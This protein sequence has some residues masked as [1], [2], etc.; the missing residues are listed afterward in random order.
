MA[1]KSAEKIPV[2][3]EPE[4][5]HTACEVCETCG[6][7]SGYI[8][9]VQSALADLGAPNPEDL[10]AKNNRYV[11]GARKAGMS[12]GNAAGMII[13]LSGADPTSYT[14]RYQLEEGNAGAEWE[15][16]GP[17]RWIKSIGR[18][19]YEIERESEGVF[20]LL[21]WDA[22][23][24]RW[25]SAK[26]PMQRIGSY[27]TFR[28]AV[29]AANS[30]A[31]SM[32]EE[33]VAVTADGKRVIAGPFKYYEEAR[34]EAQ[35]QAGI[36]KW[37]NEMGASE[38]A[39][40]AGEAPTYNK[41][42]RL[43]P[44][45]EK[46]ERGF[47]YFP[48][49][50]PKRQHQSYAGKDWDEDWQVARGS[51]K[52]TWGVK[53]NDATSWSVFAID[54]HGHQYHVAFAGN[55]SDAKHAAAVA[56]TQSA[57]P[58]ASEG[59]S[60]RWNVYLKGRK[61]PIEIRARS[62]QE[63]NGE[64]GHM[65]SKYRT[66]VER[67]VSLDE[68]GANESRAEDYN[69]RD[70][71]LRGAKAQGWAHI[72]AQQDPTSKGVLLYKQLG[73]AGWTSTVFWEEEGRWHIGGPSEERRFRNLPRGVTPLI[74]IETGEPDAKFE[75]CVQHVKQSSPDAIP[76]PCATPPSAASP[77]R[78]R[79]RTS[80]GTARTTAATGTTTATSARLSSSSARATSETKSSPGSRSSRR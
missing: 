17:G 22:Y 75:R 73:T 25:S 10:I 44:G 3:M 60:N 74:L 47:D 77:S 9:Q 72:D 45:Y 79:A 12:P 68:D 59:R 67:V 14:P 62:E 4:Q 54:R 55:E 53:Q 11:R 58:G 5:D 50:K 52:W 38:A 33:Y 64:V 16:V 71:A 35:K 76:G 61:T 48:E 66:T 23:T 19:N 63:A 69:S 1:K 29:D 26:T 37:A 30:T 51:S 6:G 39:E 80:T 13:G 42:A 31:G 41:Q 65:A 40:G 24:D 78:T 32:A 20:V 21:R 34:L 57:S 8:E 2:A 36:V 70:A 18:Y 28:E 27:P 15:E 56:D 7:L 43:P 49:W 46:W